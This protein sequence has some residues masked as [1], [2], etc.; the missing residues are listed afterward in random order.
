MES[1]KTKN[2]LIAC[3]GSVATIK[4]PE[5]VQLFLNEQQ[6]FEVNVSVFF[7][8][9]LRDLLNITDKISKWWIKDHSLRQSLTPNLTGLNFSILMS[10]L[11][12]RLISIPDKDNNHTQGHAFLLQ[13][14]SPTFR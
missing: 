13:T 14:E 12:I 8:S 7:L 5:L 6:D 10:H 4:L 9:K 11:L 1:R 3:S 2:I